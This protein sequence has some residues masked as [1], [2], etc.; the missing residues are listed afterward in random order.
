MVLFNATDL[1]TIPFSFILSLNP[2]DQKLINPQIN[3]GTIDENK[4][5][6]VNTT[7]IKLDSGASVSIAR[8]D[9]L[10]AGHRILKLKK[11]KWSSMLRTFHTTS[12]IE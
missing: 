5:S 7:K 11:N 3:L 9:V 12:I 2:H 1:A 4:N 8:K 6:K 10:Q